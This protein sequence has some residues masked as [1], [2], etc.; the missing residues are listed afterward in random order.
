MY[1]YVLVRDAS[2]DTCE[3]LDNLTKCEEAISAFELATG[4]TLPRPPPALP[5][6][7]AASPAPLAA[8]VGFAV[9][10][11][12]PGDLGAA[13]P[14]V[15]R[16]TLYWWLTDGWPGQ[17]ST[18]ARLCPRGAFSYAVA[19]SRQTSALYGTA[20]SLLDATSY[21]IRW[22]TCCSPRPPPLGSRLTPRRGPGPGG[23]PRLPSGSP[24][25]GHD[26]RFVLWAVTACRAGGPG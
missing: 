13:L 16:M 19:Y 21:G 14:V 7:A 5:G 18:V 2:G 17:R 24:A 3:P 15:G 9:E 22:V 4:S 10:A 23:G 25:P 1:Q 6:R 20:D 11:A 8:P 12:P 26:V